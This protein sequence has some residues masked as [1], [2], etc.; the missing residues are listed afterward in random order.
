VTKGKTRWSELL[1]IDNEEWKVNHIL[2]FKPTKN[3]KL[4]WFQYRVINKIKLQTLFLI[5][6]IKKVNSKL[7][8][9]CHREEETIEH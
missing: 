5:F 6:K 3:S 2:P 9:F 4:Q 1:E 7:C 8:T